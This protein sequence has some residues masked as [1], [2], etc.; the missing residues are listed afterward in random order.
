[1]LQMAPELKHR[2]Y[3]ITIGHL[4][5]ATDIAEAVKNVVPDFEYKL[6]PGKGPR[7]IPDA[8]LDI[9]RIRQ[10]LGFEPGYTLEETIAD[11]IGWLR[12]GNDN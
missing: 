11:Y 2:E 3:N 9:T 4:V 1:M 10:G 7:Y 6:E 8:Y 12:A 5:T